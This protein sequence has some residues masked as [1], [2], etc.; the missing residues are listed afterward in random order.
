MRAKNY[1][2]RYDETLEEM[3]ELSANTSAG[4]QSAKLYRIGTALLEIA[5]AESDPA[6]MVHLALNADDDGAGG[7]RYTASLSRTPAPKSAQPAAP[8]EPTE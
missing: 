7:T 3:R 1:Q 6:D 5:G 8:A 4:S 2:G